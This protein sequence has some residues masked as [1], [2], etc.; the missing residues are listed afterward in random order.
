MSGVLDPGLAIEAHRVLTLQNALADSQWMS[1][2]EIEARQFRELTSLLAHAYQTV[3][4]QRA[5]LE[6]AGYRPG[7]AVD[8]DLWRAIPIIGRAPLQDEPEA[9][10]SNAVPKDHGEILSVASSGS[11]GSPL[12]ILGTALDA[13]YSKAFTLRKLLWHD[14]DFTKTLA[15]IREARQTALGKRYQRWG[16]LLE[17]PFATGPAY[18]IDIHVGVER[19]AQWLSHIRPEYLLAFPS[20]IAELAREFDREAVGLDR[21][22]AVLCIAEIVTPELRALVA[23]R[24]GARCIDL[25]SARECGPISLECPDAPDHRHHVMAERVKV[26]VLDAEGE[27]VA[28]GETGRLI[29][30][31]LHN[32][33]QPM[34]RYEIG[35]YAVQGGLCACGRGL[36]VLTQIKG[37]VRNML[38][39]ANGKRFWPSFMTSALFG[40]LPLRQ[41]QFVQTAPGKLRCKLVT[42]RPLTAEEEA[43]FTTHVGD[44]LPGPWQITIDH[45]DQIPRGPGGKYDDSYA[46]DPM[47]T[48]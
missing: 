21:L 12:R 34:I 24:W 38:T 28:E 15:A 48:K 25:Y 20:N 8:Q 13:A 37:R 3:P 19:Q 9:W 17:Y 33:A 42:T 27:P 6:T 32:Y 36:P 35:D 4:A 18:G 29:I 1:P 2:D 46:E 30:S 26:E 5:R 23:E 31:V 41:H 45:V 44:A 39:A 7:M 11:T 16:D 14:I 22:D 10:R 40:K 43:Y 47:Q